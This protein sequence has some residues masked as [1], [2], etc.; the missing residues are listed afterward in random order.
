[1]LRSNNFPQGSGTQILL[2]V[3]TL[4]ISN[5]IR[6]RWHHKE[7]KE[8]NPIPWH[9]ISKSKNDYKL[10]DVRRAAAA[11]ADT[12]GGAAVRRTTGTK[13]I[14]LDIVNYLIIII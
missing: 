5:S 9:S 11:V 14:P 3:T 6:Y 8:G 7:T 4:P 1:M 2:W 12:A 10:G 13:P